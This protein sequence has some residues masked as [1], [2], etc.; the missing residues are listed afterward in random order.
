MF[1]EFKAFISQGSVVDLTVGVLVGAAFG[2]VV[3]A[4]MDNIIGPIMGLA[5]G[6][7]DLSK[8]KVILKEA[9]AAGVGEVAITY[10]TFINVLIQFV[11]TMFVI[12]MIV[13]AVNKTKKPVVEAPAGPSEVDLLTEIRD[14][15]KK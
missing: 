6:G 13:K 11:I 15:L 10:G 8:L 3:A 12:F 14:S 4:F 1:K 7:A 5:M 9:D 2:K